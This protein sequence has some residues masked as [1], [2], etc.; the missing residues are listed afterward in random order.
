MVNAFQRVNKEILGNKVRHKVSVKK[1]NRA[2]EKGAE[3]GHMITGCKEKKLSS[4]EILYQHFYSYAMSIC[5]RYTRNSEDAKNM[6]NDG[7]IT[8]F[9]N[10]SSYD[11]SIPFESWLG[12]I[13]IDT[14]VNNYRQK[15]DSS[16]DRKLDFV[17]TSIKANTA[18]D[19]LSPLEL[20]EL[21]QKLK[22]L[23]RFV[24]SL[25]VIDRYTHEAI[26]KKLNISVSEST[27]NL[28]EARVSLMKMAEY[29][30]KYE[31]SDV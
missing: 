3:V 4:Y 13:M 16:D 11:Y 23:N 19:K 7:F 31:Y 14:A 6:L 9:S 28:D 27:S 17:E 5:M 25:Y 22:P 10:I 29:P 1:L 20:L 12:E 2:E 18:L 8:V 15:S 21:V 24:F 30:E 26:A